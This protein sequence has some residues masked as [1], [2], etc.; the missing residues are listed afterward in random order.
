MDVVHWIFFPVE[1]SFEVSLTG[2]LSHLWLN[3]GKTQDYSHSDATPLYYIY[4]YIYIYLHMAGQGEKFQDEKTSI[5]KWIIYYFPLRWK[6]KYLIVFC[7]EIF[8]S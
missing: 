3:I 6:I 5:H 1:L 7:T 8:D 2:L 4:I